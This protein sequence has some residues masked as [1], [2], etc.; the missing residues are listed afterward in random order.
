MLLIDHPRP[1]V[2]VCESGADATERRRTL[3]DFAAKD[4]VAAMEAHGPRV[5]IKARN[6][7]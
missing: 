6:G 7:R 1:P 3:E 2:F 5:K 4:R